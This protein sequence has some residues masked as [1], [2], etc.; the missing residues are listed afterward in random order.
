MDI[1]A[2][3]VLERRRHNG[4]KKKLFY[5]EFKNGAKVNLP[6]KFIERFFTVKNCWWAEPFREKVIVGI[7]VDKRWKN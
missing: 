3:L 4:T 6:K 5:L 2:H 7:S 1:D